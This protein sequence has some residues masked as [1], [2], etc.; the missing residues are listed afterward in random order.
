MSSS[1]ITP[2]LRYRDPQMAARWLCRAFGFRINKVDDQAGKLPQFITLDAGESTILIGPAFGTLL[3]D[4]LVQPEDVGGLG[5]QVCYLTVDDITEHRAAAVAAGATIEKGPMSNE[6]GS[7]YYICRDLEGHIW[8]FGTHA[9]SPA[10]SAPI[11][12]W[13]QLKNYV[14]ANGQQLH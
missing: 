11:R 7:T 10:Q 14:G 6:D 4:W 13:Q 2:L 3:D 12:L 9:L 1:S 5:T 8:S